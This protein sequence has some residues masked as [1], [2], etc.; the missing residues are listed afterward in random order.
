MTLRLYL[1]TL[2]GLST[3]T[4]KAGKGLACEFSQRLAQVIDIHVNSL[5][6]FSPH[7]TYRNFC[8]HQ[9]CFWGFEGFNNSAEAAIETD[10]IVLLIF[11]SGTILNMLKWILR[12]MLPPNTVD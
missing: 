4:G 8:L 7:L 2:S 1:V 5:L 12:I 9:T 3:K 10:Y 6:V 11:F